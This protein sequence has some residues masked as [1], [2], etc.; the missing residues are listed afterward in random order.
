MAAHYGVAIMPARSYKPKDKAKAEMSVLL[1]ER[2][3]IA[4]LRNERFTSLPDANG[5]VTELVAWVN[6]RPF[7]RLGGTRKSLFEELDRP[8][9]RPLPARRYEF[10]TWRKT[11]LAF[12]YHVEV[13]ADRHFYSA[14][15][16]LVGEVVEV[17]LSA[18]T[19][20]VLHRHNRVASHVRSYRPGF[21]TDA[22]HMPESHRQHASWTP[23]R[24]ISWAKKTGP[25]T[26][27]L[28]EAVLSER[29]HPEQ[30][31]RSCLGIIRLGKQYGTD[32][33]EAAAARALALRSH[34]Y[35]TVEPVLRCKLE[36]K[37]LPG[38]RP[39]PPAHPDHENLRGGDYF[40]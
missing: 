30:G 10:A 27:K 14:P 18:S 21:T 16:R 8:A 28:A 39:A 24:I 3:V 20:E 5:A 23:S 9:L 2:F 1:V 40:Q 36:D 7:K 11:K 31:F 29:P 22:A 19:V 25:S 12:D 6:E 37:P 35:R 13:R 15:H 34:S 26:A 17:R 33:L 38:E 4:R 32:R